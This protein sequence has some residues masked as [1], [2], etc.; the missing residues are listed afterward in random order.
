MLTE[1]LD[2]LLNQ[3]TAQILILSIP[4]IA[5]SEFGLPVPVFLESILLFAGFK[6]SQGQIIYFLA[7]LFTLV[8]SSLG[9][10]ILYLLAIFFGDE[11][12][13]RY[14]FFSQKR[15]K[16]EKTISKYGG[17]E[18][19]TMSIL[20]LTPALV[21]T[22]LAAGFLKINYWKFFTSVIISALIYNLVF[23][24]L[25]VILGKNATLIASNISLIFEITLLIIIVP[26]L[27]FLGIKVRELNKNRNLR[28]KS[29]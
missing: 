5:I 21:P 11:I 17:W 24:T 26:V 7:T 27:I 20:R 9:A 19:F 12:L 8:G 10:S 13:S 25:G 16:I 6:I 4:I 23:I 3:G 18:V 15:E 1:I 22:T 29:L 28:P 2:F 14:K